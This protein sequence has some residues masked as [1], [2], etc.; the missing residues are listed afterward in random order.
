VAVFVT[1]LAIRALYLVGASSGPA[2]NLPLVDAWGYHKLAGAVAR[3]E[4]GPGL[5]WQSFLYPFLIAPFHLLQG[6]SGAALATKVAQA[7]LGSATCA[8]TALLALR[9]LGARAAIVAGAATALCGPMIFYDGEILTA[10]AEAFA[11][12][13][14]LTLLLAADQGGGKSIPLAAAGV[15]AGMAILLRPTFALPA[16]VGLLWLLRRGDPGVP[17]R[18]RLLRFLLPAAGVAVPLL[19]ASLL[20]LSVTGRFTPLPASG[21]INLAIGNNADYC[22]S[23]NV[24]PGWEWNRL[25]RRPSEEGYPG[26]WGRNDYWSRRAATFITGEP[27]AFISGLGAKALRLVSAREIPRNDDIYLYRGWS[28]L[29]S[30]SVFTVGGFGFPFGIFFPMAAVGFILGRRRLPW[31]L[32]AFGIALAVGIVLVFPAGRYRVP[33]LP[34]LAVA[35]AAGTEEM[36]RAWR[37]RHRAL[38]AT[39]AGIIVTALALSVLPGPFCEERLDYRTEMLNSLGVSAG[40]VGRLSESLAWH[41]KAVERDPDYVDAWNNIGICLIRMQ[42]PAEAVAAFDEALRRTPDLAEAWNN[43]G[44]ALELLSNLPEAERSLRRAVALFPRYAVAL[45][46]LG[47]VLEAEG[48]FQEALEAYAAAAYDPDYPAPAKRRE[49]LL[50]RLGLAR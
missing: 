26:F 10:S 18:G 45:T 16:S 4:L 25:M 17:L 23:V 22:A 36:L 9:L 8:M 44:Y 13:A 34:L 50:R 27:A 42:R 48:R 24:R 46:S 40:E 41:Q 38:L 3:G 31:L 37:L 7:L 14:L 5:F 35:A 20:C 49:A 29:L 33:L 6:P 11:A 1:A 21:G 43:R 28:T 39:A 2:F 15:A 30:A 47:R 19:A 12:V 32:P